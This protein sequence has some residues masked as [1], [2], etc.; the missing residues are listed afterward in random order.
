MKKVLVLLSMC[1]L[2]ACTAAPAPKKADE[3][4]RVPVNKTV[5]YEATLGVLQ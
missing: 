4:N 1:A 5:P 2:C 3:S